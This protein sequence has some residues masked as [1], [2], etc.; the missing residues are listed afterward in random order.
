[1]LDYGKGECK[2]Y[3]NYKFIKTDDRYVEVKKKK[4]N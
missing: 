2:A 4:T 3:S 1:M